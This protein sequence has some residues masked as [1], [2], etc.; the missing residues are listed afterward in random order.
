M[1]DGEPLFRIRR[2]VPADAPAIE[3]P[4]ARSVRGLQANDYS[5]AQIAGAVGTVFGVDS[6]IGKGFALDPLRM[7]AR[8]Q[9]TEWRR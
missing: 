4:I 3:T 2:A 6:Q 5:A 1:K 7:E 9:E 8:S